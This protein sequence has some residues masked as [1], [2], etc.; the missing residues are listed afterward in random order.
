MFYSVTLYRVGAI[1][2]FD[3]AINKSA[4]IG[5]PMLK[6][7]QGAVTFLNELNVS[8]YPRSLLTIN[9]TMLV[10]QKNLG[11]LVILFLD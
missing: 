1:Y 6:L 11:D 4:L 7:N 5:I 10:T 2:P 9:A 3:A 8:A